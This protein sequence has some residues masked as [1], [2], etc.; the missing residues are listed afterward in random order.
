MPGRTVRS[1][2]VLLVVLIATTVV[3]VHRAADTSAATSQGFY[4]DIGAS[5][6]LGTQ[7]DGVVAHN[8]H[9]TKHGYSDDLVSLESTRGV[10]LTMRE[11]GC[12]GETVQSMLGQIKDACYTLPNTQLT[13]ALTY[14]HE[15]LGEAGVVTIDLGFN[16]IRPCLTAIATIASCVNQGIVA[17]RNDL[18]IVI[19]RLQHAAGPLVHFIG[20]GYGDPFLAFYLQGPTGRAV[21]GQGLAAMNQM[22]AVLQQVYN[23]RHVPMANVSKSF[24]SENATMVTSA[25]LG[26]LPDNVVTACAYTWMCTRPPFGPDDH[27]NNAGYSAIALAIFAKLSRLS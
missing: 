9:R 6:S 23:E 12:P 18:P 19:N 10:A 21:A 14:L 13:I 11:I 15:H 25:K 8:G 5:S 3:V 17:V 2:L 7:P 26:V 27:P 20:L 16:N 1:L 4:L 24:Q 22:N